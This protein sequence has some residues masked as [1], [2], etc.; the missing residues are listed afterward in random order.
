MTANSSSGIN[1]RRSVYCGILAYVLG[2]GLVVGSHWLGIH[3]ERGLWTRSGF[4]LGE[5]LILHW[6]V[7]LPVWSATVH[8]AVVAHTVSLAAV[9]VGAGYLCAAITAS[10]DRAIEAGASIVL[11]YGG[12]TFL[13]FGYVLLTVETAIWMELVA[14]ALLVSVVV[15]VVYGGIGGWLYRRRHG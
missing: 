15:P 5:Y 1:L 6:G 7:Q 11:G 14:P 12:M 2:L 10:S 8:F 9:L 3:P 4:S 13:A